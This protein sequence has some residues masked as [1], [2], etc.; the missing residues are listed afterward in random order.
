MHFYIVC[1]YH[2]QKMGQFESKEW[3]QLDN[4]CWEDSRLILLMWD[5]LIGH[6]YDK[7]CYAVQSEIIT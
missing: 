5:L 7:E 1:I 3:L 4:M 2:S 6:R